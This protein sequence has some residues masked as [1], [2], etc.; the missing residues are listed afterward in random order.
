MAVRFPDPIHSV[1]PVKFEKYQ[2]ID[3]L[4]TCLNQR[5]MALLNTYRD[6]RAQIS[7]RHIARAR[8]EELI[9]AKIQIEAC[10]RIN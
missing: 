2:L 6:T 3:H 9:R 5:R 7:A 8:K 4:I 10:L 1:D